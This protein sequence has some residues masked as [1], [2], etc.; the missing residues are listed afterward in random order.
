ML[1][2]RA[3]HAFGRDEQAGGVGEAAFEPDLPSDFPADRPAALVRNSVRDGSRRHAPRLQE[4]ERPS[5]K[6]GRRNPRGFPCAR[7]RR[8]DER[9]R[10]PQIG[11]DLRKEGVDRKDVSHSSSSRLRCPRSCVVHRRAR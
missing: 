3:Q 1:E 8:D 11:D 7:L 5:V 6:Q 4:D 9:T 10:L 2:A